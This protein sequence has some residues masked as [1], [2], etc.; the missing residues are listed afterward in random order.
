MGR[1]QP[2]GPEGSQSVHGFGGWDT[3]CPRRATPYNTVRHRPLFPV[4]ESFV[5]D[6][7]PE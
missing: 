5:G 1:R 6:F 2:G 7:E 4:L 3:G